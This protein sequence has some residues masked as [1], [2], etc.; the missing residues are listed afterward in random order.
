MLFSP[1]KQKKDRLLHK[2]DSGTAFLQEG[3]SHLSAAGPALSPAIAR[4]G[5]QSHTH[6][7]EPASCRAVKKDPS[8][9]PTSTGTPGALR[10]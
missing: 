8:A 2:M 10:A 5:V 1:G 4:P 6:S 3:W 9:A 7:S